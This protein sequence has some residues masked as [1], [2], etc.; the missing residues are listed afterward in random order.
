MTAVRLFE[1]IVVTREMDEKVSN[2]VSDFRNIGY[3]DSGSNNA[4]SDDNIDSGSNN[5][6]SDDCHSDYESDD[7]YEN[8]H[9]DDYDGTTLPVTQHDLG[10][11]VLKKYA[12]HLLCASLAR[13]NNCVNPIETLIKNA[14]CNDRSDYYWLAESLANFE[15]KG[16]SV[17]EGESVFDRFFSFEKKNDH[18]LIEYPYEYDEN[19][20]EESFPFE[21]RVELLSLCL[22]DYG[23]IYREAADIYLEFGWD[24]LLDHS[25]RKFVNIDDGEHESDDDEAHHPD[26]VLLDG[27]GEDGNYVPNDVP[28]KND[29]EPKYTFPSRTPWVSKRDYPEYQEDAPKKLWGVHLPMTQNQLGMFV[30]KKI[31]LY[32]NC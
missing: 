1:Q 26:D 10:L 8:C 4:D 22:R 31:T 12:L 18:K 20:D 3:I 17:F 30:L 14:H 2:F 23:D 19:F 27:V 21:C 24:G 6:D 29:E 9:S 32:I 7:D 25:T 15:K 11:F 16:E 5:A 28:S 13:K